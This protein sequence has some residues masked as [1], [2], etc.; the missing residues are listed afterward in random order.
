MYDKNQSQD[1]RALHGAVRTSK[2]KSVSLAL[3]GALLGYDIH[4]KKQLLLQMT[5]F[6]QIGEIRKTL[7]PSY[8][9]CNLHGEQ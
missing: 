1:S 5:N 3:Q 9:S 6:M 7:R 4:E 8:D 2:V